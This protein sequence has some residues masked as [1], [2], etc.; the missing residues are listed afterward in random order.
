MKRLRIAV[1]DSNR[2][3]ADI[4]ALAGAPE[5]TYVNLTY[6]HVSDLTP[7]AG[8]A[9]LTKLSFYGLSLTVGSPS[10]ET[11]V[12]L[13]LRGTELLGDAWVMSE[14]RAEIERRR[15]AAAEAR[16]AELVSQPSG[17]DE[18]F[19]ALVKAG[20][21]ELAW[22]WKDGGPRV[23]D[24][25]GRTLLHLLAAA[26][27]TDA[28]VRADLTRRLVAAGCDLD[29]VQ[30]CAPATTALGVAV[31][32]LLGAD[33]LELLLELGADPDA[34]RSR[35]P[36]LIALEQGDTKSIEILAAAGASLAAVFDTI[37][38]RGSLDLVKRALDDAP[39]LV[40]GDAL[41]RATE[42]KREDVVRVLLERGAD[43]NVRNEHGQT[44]LPYVETT[45]MFDLLVAAGADMSARG[46]MRETA[47]FPYARLA[48]REAAEALVRRAVAAGAKLHATA[49][50]GK[51]LHSLARSRDVRAPALV[52]VLVELGAAMDD[53]VPGSVLSA[54]DLAQTEPMKAALQA[55]KV[56]T[57]KTI[58]KRLAKQLV[59]LE[60]GD[61]SAWA[62]AK[63]LAAAR[64]AKLLAPVAPLLEQKLRALGDPLASAFAALGPTSE[65]VVVLLA[66]GVN[67]VDASGAPLL[68]A[69]IANAAL[70]EPVRQAALRALL[71]AGA[72]PEALDEM[73][74]PALNAYLDHVRSWDFELV[75]QLATATTVRPAISRGPLAI[76]AAN[77]TMA[78]EPR[79]AVVDLLVERGAELARPD[80]LGAACYGGR[81][82]LV[83]RAIESGAAIPVAA[84]RSAVFADAAAIVTHL[85]E[86][87]ADANACATVRA[88]IVDARSLATLDALLAHGADPFVLTREGETPLHLVA[89][90]TAIDGPTMVA[91]VERLERLGLSRS[92]PDATGRTPLDALRSRSEPEIR[93]L[94]G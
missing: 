29:A 44:A 80:A 59:S 89:R 93:A 25:R 77:G 91:M 37:V 63:K 13:G 53:L 26:P 61:A 9:R 84:L 11:L 21:D 5:L 73:G 34:G 70:A 50:E 35:P 17:D 4:T 71:A 47:L 42:R 12:T 38:E 23:R 87:G 49:L 1:L 83:R 10:F 72:D 92:L 69:V 15:A 27:R 78:S 51:V 46:G 86:H 54:L 39:L 79:R 94:I 8:L 64:Q 3:L 45:A 67:G 66:D 24:A 22:L 76:A 41:V 32:K 58:A 14:L 43:A 60:A 56:A 20:L 65:A 40:R 68:H 88:P 81:L 52:P 55:A 31:A 36:M 16:H 74:T 62:A 30:L 33:Y 7:L 2:A 90:N 48:D 85:L 57:G 75:A 19:D 6:T 28:A 18:L 82:D